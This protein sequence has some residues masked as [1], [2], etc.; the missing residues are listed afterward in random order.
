VGKK[1]NEAP[2]QVK[3]TPKQVEELQERLQKNELTKDDVNLLQ[4]V[5][6]FTLWIQERLS[7]AKLTIKRLSKL[8]GFKN[9]SSKKYKKNEDKNSESSDVGPDEDASTDDSEAAVSEVAPP[10]ENNQQ[11]K[12]LPHLPQWDDSKNHGRLSAQDYEGC[13][14]IEIDFTDGL[15]LA[16]KCPDCAQHYNTDAQISSVDPT[17]IV[18]LEGKPL[19]C[20]KRYHLQKGRCGVCNKYF[21]A[22]L[23]K[24][25]EEAPK[26]APSAKSNIAINHY[27]GGLPFKR[28]EML[29]AASQVPLPD[30]TQ[31]DLMNALY[32]SSI[33]PIARVLRQHGANGETL[34]FDDTTA[35]ILEQIQRNKV[36]LSK[37]AKKA[38]H[39]TAMVSIYEGRRIY[40]FDTNADVAK[41]S[42]ASLLANRTTDQP[43]TTMSDAS[44]QN[45]PIL[46]D[47]L[48]AR[49]II[50]LCLSHGRRR[51]FELL[52]D[53]NDD[54]L[55]FVLECIAKVYEHERYCKQQLYDPDQ[56]LRYHQQHSGPLIE[57]LRIW[58]NNLL[59]H[60]LV[61]PN[62]PL[63]E[64]IEYML[65][66][67]FWLTQF[68]RV[69]GAPL[70]NNLCEQ[71]IK[72]LIR[73]R[74]N[75]LFYRTF[76][77]ATMGD[78]MMGV[79]HTAVHAGANLFH[80]LNS[81]QDYAHHVEHTPD[82]WLPWSYEQ[83]I[84]NLSELNPLAQAA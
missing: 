72:V 44:A 53:E 12:N 21:T 30:A 66:R 67:W 63:G 60:K 82:Q 48:A 17:V 10:P 45:F 57:A 37:K 13:E 61:E 55:R 42:V 8:F 28:I 65:K 84:K 64:A 3:L 25:I 15:L 83:T 2:K 33:K 16:G 46:N 59:L 51:F 4:G 26:Y 68:L 23:P 80:Y 6:N 79:M 31:F 71:T 76:Y 50:S 20:G 34:Y 78:A 77:G 1:K 38:V 9:E 19:V 43:F 47:H 73:Y 54:D 70:D 75:S 58:L 52:G 62:S 27:Y 41:Y 39:G 40:L 24:D 22:P 7:R 32:Q 74:K 18:L 81:L 5:L 35:R 69:A 11:S 56:R 14:G 49:W 36:A 29:Q